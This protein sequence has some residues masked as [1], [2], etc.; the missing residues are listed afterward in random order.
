MNAAS[1][2]TALRSGKPYPMQ[3]ATGTRGTTQICGPGSRSPD[4]D[5]AGRDLCKS[6]DLYLPARREG[7]KSLNRMCEPRQ[8]DKL[9]KGSDKN[10]QN[11]DKG[12]AGQNKAP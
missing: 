3:K 12:E 5:Q 2:I 4:T 10:R 6:H 11:G 7:Q 8:G 1:H 9:G